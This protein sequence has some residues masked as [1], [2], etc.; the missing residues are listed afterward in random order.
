MRRFTAMIL[1][2]CFALCGC[3]SSSEKGQQ[4]LQDGQYTEA[5]AYFQKLIDEEKELTF[6]YY[7]MGISC[8]E[9]KEYEDA[10]AFL[11]HALEYK[12]ENTAETYSML[13]A[14]NIELKQ[15]EEA[16]EFYQKALKDQNLTD[17]L[18]QEI[19]YN[20]IAVYEY[21]GE[22]ENAEQQLNHYVENYPTDERLEKEEIFLETR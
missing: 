13:G 9:L 21:L 15:Y 5:K 1:V 19:E 14:C 17:G 16:L 10:A 18:K 6:A 2:L 12:T 4:F 3:G 22:W 8:F 11:E 20:L 7:G